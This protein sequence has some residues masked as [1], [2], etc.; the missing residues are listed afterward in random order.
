VDIKA[1]DRE[2]YRRLANTPDLEGVLDSARRAKKA[3]GLHVE[4]VTNLVPGFNDEEAQLRALAD[5]IVAELGPETP[6]HVTRFIPHLDLGHVPPTPVATLERARAI[7]RG[8]KRGSTDA[9][10]FP[11]MNRSPESGFKPSRWRLVVCANLYYYAS[12]GCFSEH[13]FG[14]VGSQLVWCLGFECSNSLRIPGLVEAE[15]GTPQAPLGNLWTR[16]FSATFQAIPP[17]TPGAT[18]VA[19]C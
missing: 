7:G 3:H 8:Q 10:R 12:E 6:W 17:R 14:C 5:W 2:A 15:G 18:P 16:L 1:F 9:H 4:C 13:I 19:R 11:Q